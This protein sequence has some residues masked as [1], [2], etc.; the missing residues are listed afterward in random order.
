MN[1]SKVAYTFLSTLVNGDCVVK[2]DRFPCTILTRLV[3]IFKSSS[4]V[5]IKVSSLIDSLS[6]DGSVLWLTRLGVISG[7]GVE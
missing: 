4:L 5:V 3:G 1:L 6:F 2:V 7:V